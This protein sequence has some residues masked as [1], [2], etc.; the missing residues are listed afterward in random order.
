MQTTYDLKHAVV[1]NRLLGLWRMI[2]DYRWTYIGAMITLTIAAA[3]KTTTFLL[4]RYFVDEALMG[5]HPGVAERLTVEGYS[6]KHDRVL[7]YTQLV[8]ETFA[9]A[10]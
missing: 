1:S 8:G 7:W 5:A 9:T 10:Q 2:Y 3:A 4:L 6:N